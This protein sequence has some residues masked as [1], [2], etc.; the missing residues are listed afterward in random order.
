[1]SQS[2]CIATTT[3]SGASLQIERE[4]AERLLLRAGFESRDPCDRWI[5]PDGRILT[6]E[7]ALP[8][9]VPTLAAVA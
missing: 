7:Q 3:A 2:S 6:S 9:A 5:T 8:E 1:M 4:E